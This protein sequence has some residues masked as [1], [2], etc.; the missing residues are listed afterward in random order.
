MI[1]VSIIG[2]KKIA[3]AIVAVIV[4]GSIPFT[5]CIFSSNPMAIDQLQ[6]GISKEA[7]LTSPIEDV[8]I[9]TETFGYQQLLWVPYPS[10]E[11]QELATL[12]S[13][14]THCYVYMENSCIVTQGESNAIAKCDEL[15]DVFDNTIYPKGVE[16]AGNPDGNLGDIDGDPKVTLF[17]GPF[18]E[19]SGQVINGYYVPRNELEVPFS[20]YRE[21]FY[22]DATNTVYD[23]VC[24]SCHEFNHLIWFN[25]ELDEADFLLEGLANFAIQY[26]GYWGTIADAQARRFSDNP[27]DSLL[28]FNRISSSYYWDVSY[29]QSTLFVTYLYERF[30]VDFVRSLVSIPEDGAVAID[31]ALSNEGYDLTFNDVYLDWTVACTLDNPSIFDGRYGFTSVNYTIDHYSSIGSNYPIEKAGITFNYYG[32][33]ARAIFSPLDRMTFQ[34]ENPSSYTLGISIVI[35]DSSGWS[36]TQ[37][38]HPEESTDISRTIIGNDVEEVYVIACLMSEETPTE[39]GVVYALD[40]VPSVELDYIISEGIIS[41]GND[42]VFSYLV[43]ISGATVLLICGT[44]IVYRRRISSKG[45]T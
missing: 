18:R 3:A 27:Q 25:H 11:E 37:S 12:L 34:I 41:S 7:P 32:I 10:G 4:V 19:K 21:M 42:N 23:A 15:R 9:S 16:L 31:V 20:N 26:S 6:K 33:H 2:N 44:A 36:V 14:G 1:R 40:E 29:G 39:F 30:G 38:I 28:Y 17:L 45:G 5:M 43:P 8:T 35:L 22:I 24:L 13:V